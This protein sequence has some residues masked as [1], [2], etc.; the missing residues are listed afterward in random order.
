MKLLGWF[1]RPFR[2]DGTA[3][4]LFL[5]YLFIVL[6][7]IL[8]LLVM[9]AVSV[10]VNQGY[11]SRQI[12]E[13]N[14]KSI[15]QIESG[16]ELVFDELDSIALSFS[17]SPEFLS[18]LNQII[19]TK[20]LTFEQ[21]K[22]LSTIHNFVEVS[23]SARPY[24]H[25]I[26]VY[27]QNRGNELMTTSDGIV[28]LANFYDR[29]WYTSYEQHLRD[30]AF[31][32]EIRTITRYPSVERGRRVLTIYRRVYSLI[33][34]KEPGVVVLNIKLDYFE[35]LIGRLKSNPEQTILI[36][37][38]ALKPVMSVGPQPPL[39]AI[40]LLHPARAGRPAQYTLY[41]GGRGFM[42]N[43]NRAGKNGWTYVSLTP[44]SHFYRASTTLRDLNIAI[45]AIS[46]LLGGLLTYYASRRSFRH[47]EH[48]VGIVEA[49]EQGKPLPEIPPAKGDGFGQLTY[50]ILR[51]FLEH[52]YMKVQ[53]SERRYRQRTLEL[54]ALHSQMNPHFLFNTLE[55]INWRVIE[56]TKRPTQIND[57]IG[58]FSD[59][60]KYSLE[61]PFKLETL[62][63]EL[64]HAED[65][66]A[67]QRIR[68]K[69][70]FTVVRDTPEEI[71][72]YKVIRFLL[73]PLLEN[74]IYHGLREKPGTGRIL[75]RARKVGESIH[76][77]VEDNGKGIEPQRLKDV[78][79]GLKDSENYSES[80]GLQNTSKRI[81]LAFGEGYGL[82]VESVYGEG[83]VVTVI[84]PA[85]P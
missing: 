15:G 53:L 72:G 41:L 67:I 76:L 44:L 1:R 75:L 82:A 24:V 32:T 10:V 58:S 27:T 9:G 56:L 22:V 50:S 71:G 5:R 85:R 13:S 51:T 40:R 36:L 73:Q 66:L 29:G 25:S 48:V 8:I 18:A 31:W 70:K 20:E 84:I 21:S 34:I 77:V 38:S 6:I 60:L 37:D 62:E 30:D 42:V 64:K 11:V 14:F 3:H 74:A 7:P 80:I 68:Y 12:T 45:V 59:I 23:A 79:Q 52:K 57:L 47:I 16:V 78:Q 35:S 46:F 39:G 83:T 61:S 33:D 69:D 2:P 49:A 26:Y 65:Y 55:T 81:A 4:L 28:S 17:A 63:N 19:T 43:Q 54:L